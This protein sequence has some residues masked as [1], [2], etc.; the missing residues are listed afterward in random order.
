MDVC[1]LIA[2]IIRELHLSFLS[3]QRREVMKMNL[4]LFD[5]DGGGHSSLR[6]C[7]QADVLE[8]LT[9]RSEKCN[10]SSNLVCDDDLQD[11]P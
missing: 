4:K 3:S 2:G 1:D 5:C 11:E 6:W 8:T 10:L 9:R 7:L